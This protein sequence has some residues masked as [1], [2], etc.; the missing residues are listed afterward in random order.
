MK[1]AFI[2]PIMKATHI[3]MFIL[4]KLC[5][6]LNAIQNFLQNLALTRFQDDPLRTKNGKCVVNILADKQ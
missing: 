2:R 5:E 3:C 6:F 1:L 4:V